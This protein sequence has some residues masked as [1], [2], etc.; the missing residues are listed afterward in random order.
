M[1]TRLWQLLGDAGAVYRRGGHTALTRGAFRYGRQRLPVELWPELLL[2]PIGAADRR[3]PVQETPDIQLAYEGNY[4]ESLPRPLKAAEGRT[5]GAEGAVYRYDDADVVGRR[6]IVGVDGRYFPPS[7]LG[8][9]TAFFLHQEKYLKRNLPL[10]WSLRTL[11]GS[12]PDRAIDTGFLLLG[13]RSLE[14]PAWHHE[15]LPKLQFLE[16]YEEQTG[17]SPTLIVNADLGQFHEQSL[18]LMGYDP[19]SWVDP[20][21]GAIRVRK[22]LVAPHP[23]RARGTHL[24]TTALDWVGERIRSNLP[25]R[26]DDFSKRVYVSRRDAERRRVRNETEVVDALR[27]R[28]F[29]WYEPGRLDYEEEIALFSG[30]DLIVGAHGMGLASMF[31]ASDAALVELFPRGGATEHYFLTAAE[32][33]FAYEFLSCDSIEEGGNVRARD[34]D[35]VVDTDELLS[36]IKRVE[37][38][39]ETHSDGETDVQSE[40]VR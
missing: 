18:R 21:D 3:I 25:D 29:E 16:A 28:G 38:A 23:R 20:G 32:R 8:V 34:R 17:E 35:F 6:P 33:G 11:L 2:D 4:R 31:H 22:L 27:D 26:S 39:V 12:G 15:V 19:D 7:W 1:A 13:E 30:A 10:T 14:F 40:T 24:H 36:R 5:L 37:S 9:E